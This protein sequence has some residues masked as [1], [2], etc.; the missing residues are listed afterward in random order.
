MTL[1]YEVRTRY[2]SPEIFDD[3]SDAAE[4]ITS[5]DEYIDELEV[6]VDEY[7]DESWG[8]I[9]I[10]GRDYEASRILYALNEEDYYDLQNE[11]KRSCAEGNTD[12]ICEQIR[13]MDEGD[14]RNY[15]GGITVTCIAIH[16]EEDDEEDPEFDKEFGSIFEYSA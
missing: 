3:A 8:H 5:N 12:W 11:E 4:Y 7:I 16:D 9:E 2:G 6:D 10:N 14:E 1:Q 13:E 15:Y